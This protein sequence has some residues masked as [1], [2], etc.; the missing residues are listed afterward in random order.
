[1]QRNNLRRFT[2]D[3]ARELAAIIPNARLIELPGTAL[4]A[5]AGD[6]TPVI[7]TIAEALGG[8]E[9]EPS[10]GAQ[11]FRTILFTD[12][13]SSTALTQHLGDELAQEI[14]RGHNATVRS[15]LADHSGGEVK[16][17]GDGIMAS[18]SSVVSAVR[19]A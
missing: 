1:M 18:F 17:T 10:S 7:A 12:I 13:E 11:T 16:H 5:F 2:F 4:P 15:A 3:V 8:A 9:A 6:T 19:A 14:L